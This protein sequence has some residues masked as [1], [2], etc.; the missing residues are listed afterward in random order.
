LATEVLRYF[1][2]CDLSNET[3]NVEFQQMLL[4]GYQTIQLQ[5]L[6]MPCLCL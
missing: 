1:E 3:E 4:W 2:F 5:L 6:I